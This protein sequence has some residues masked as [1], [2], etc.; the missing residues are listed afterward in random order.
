MKI[1][2]QYDVAEQTVIEVINNRTWVKKSVGNKFRSLTDKQVEEIKEVMLSTSITDKAL[3]GRYKS[4]R[5]AMRI[6]RRSLSNE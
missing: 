5:R 1:A 2:E 6:I 3:A 4:N